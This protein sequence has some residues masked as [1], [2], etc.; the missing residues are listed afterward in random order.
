MAERLF[1][2]G[3]VERAKELLAE[4]EDVAK[5]LFADATVPYASLRLALAAAHDNADR[6]L[7]WLDKAGSNVQP[8]GGR[9]AAKF[10]PDRP[11]RAVEVWKRIVAANRAERIAWRNRLGEPTPVQHGEYR[12]GAEFCYRLAL[13]DRALAEQ[14]AADAEDEAM[15]FWQQGAVILALAETQPAEARRRLTALVREDLPQVAK[16]PA[17]ENWP[18]PLGSP[19]AI[20]AWLLPVAEKVA[21]DLCRELF[22]RSLAL[23]LPRPRRDDLNGQVEGADV[24]LAKLL[25]RYDR[26]TAR[27]LL[28]PV[29]ADATASDPERVVMA[30][31]TGGFGIFLAAVH[32]DPRWAKSLLDAVGDSPA[33]TARA[34]QMRHELVC[35]LALPLPDR[36]NA[37]NAW[38]N[39]FSAGFWAPAA[40]DK[41]LP[42]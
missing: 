20:A 25:A 31:L 17:E 14:I 8:G 36:W 9:L 21:P 28:E 41:P 13:A 18:L 35:T 10:L 4:A 33:W 26:D 15:G 30:R 1:G 5:S 24:Q 19:P 32:T 34:D 12:A 39:L 40:R 7:G 38:R 23:R 3:E 6:A 27:A 16:L 42:P 11:Q 37:G 2:L 22:W 29:A